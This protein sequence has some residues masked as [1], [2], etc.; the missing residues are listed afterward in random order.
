MDGAARYASFLSQ[1]KTALPT[2]DGPGVT[3]RLTDHDRDGVRDLYAVDH[4]SRSLVRVRVLSGASGYRTALLD[5]V[6]PLRLDDQASWTFDVVD[7]DGDG[8][9]DLVA[10][11]GQG[12]S[13]TEVHAL[14]GASRLRS[15]QLNT[16]TALHRTAPSAWSFT[17][18]DHDRDGVPDLYAIAR[19]GASGRTEVHVLSGASGFRAWLT[20]VAT[21]LGPTP[22]A[23]G[24]FDVGDA[25]GNGRDDL[26]VVLRGGASG[27]TEV[28]VLDG[29]TRG[30]SCTRRRRCRR[31]RARRA[32]PSTWPGS[33]TDQTPPRRAVG[34]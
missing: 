34:I 14:S 27:R 19:A 26:V 25:D 10:V 33:P 3:Y 31:P 28:H 24:S 21:P 30:G 22:S 8:H 13:G 5:V 29:T 2:V 12:Q 6:S 15:W 9:L 20:H 16:G 4:P 32:G 18:G 1:S 11:L 17:I 23:T 7:L